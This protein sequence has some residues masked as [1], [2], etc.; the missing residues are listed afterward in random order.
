ML[1]IHTPSSPI[2]EAGSV[3]RDPDFDPIDID[4]ERPLLLQT[5]SDTNIVRNRTGVARKRS[6][7]RAPISGR[8]TP[9][10]LVSG[11]VT[12]ELPHS[13]KRH[14]SFNTFVE[15]CMA[16]EDP[17]EH[18]IIEEESDD[19]MLEM[20]SSSASSSSR[21]SRPS[22]SRNSS[23]ASSDHLTIAMIAPTM[24]K[25]PGGNY[26]S[27]APQMIY[28]P[29]PEYISPSIHHPSSAA[30]QFDFPSPL[31]TKSK[32]NGDEDD[33]YGSV[34]FDYFGGPENPP[35]EASHYGGGHGRQSLQPQPQPTPPV[36]PPLVGQ[37]P[38]QAKWR[39]GGGSGTT[40]ASTSEPPSSHS[41]SLSVS[42][43]PTISP[44]QPTR[45]ILKVRAPGTTPPIQE[46]NSPPNYF[47]YK[48]SAATGIGGMRG[49]GYE[50]APAT[51]PA[52]VPVE[53]GSGSPAVSPSPVAEDVSVTRGRAPPPPP[54]PTTTTAGANEPRERGR[55][56]A[57]Q[58]PSALNDRS[59][60][61][62]TTSSTQSISPASSRSPVEYSSTTGMA[63]RSSPA[64]D[65]VDEDQHQPRD[66]F[67]MSGGAGQGSRDGM[68]VDYS[69]ERSSTPTPHSS[70]QVSRTFHPQANSS[71]CGE[72]MHPSPLAFT[73]IPQR[74]RRDP[75]R[76]SP[77]FAGFPDP[78]SPVWLFMLTCIRY[79]SD[80]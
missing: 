59:T 50:P 43:N 32:W 30:A 54:P 78:L 57:R 67:L 56:A 12:P 69:P 71:T 11:E 26:S 24:L 1:A 31:Q 20:R 60:S 10:P 17:T 35:Q 40:S 79:H 72:C 4:S 61:R 64:L 3:D 39:T 70:P 62:G 80:H 77:F 8:N 2:L 75:T 18:N 51:V 73:R 47:D 49:S 29:P 53:S 23:S 22:M 16:V 7:T 21:S 48:P 65:K 15:Q 38:P 68:E 37:P 76:P 52:S 46:I 19:D 42:P 58:G 66:G 25:T 28:A 14:I 6:P 55:S 33:E 36:Q 13:S 44:P 63:K 27:S 45:G 41:S 34:G 5:K 74:S 9:R